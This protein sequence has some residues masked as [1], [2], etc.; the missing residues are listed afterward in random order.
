MALSSDLISQFVQVTKEEKTSKETT[1]YGTIVEYNGGKYVKLDG[2]ELL[3]PISLT[4]DAL[5]GERVTVMIKDHTATVT[6]NLSSPSARTDTVKD[7]DDSVQE[8]GSKVSE[9]EIVIA[10]KVSTKRLEAEIARI[11]T[12]VSENV[13][14]NGRLEANEAEISDLTADNVTINEKLTAND[15]EIENLKAT[16]IDA[17]VVEATYA[18]IE[19]L[20]ATNAHINNLEVTYGK[21]KDLTTDKLTAVDATISNLEVNKLNVT[22]AEIKYANID[23]AN[24]N[25]AAVEK[26]FADS[27][28]I[29]DLIVS[30]GTIT[31][32]LVGVTIK[33]DL[34]E[35]NTIV[36]D[37]LVVKGEDGLYY[38]LNTDGVTTEAEQTDYNSLNGT[39]IQAKSVTAEKIRVDDLVAFGATIGGYHITD[40]AL[41]SGAKESAT[42]TTRG[43][44][45]DNDGQF[46]VGDSTN[47]LRYYK[48]QNGKYELEVSAQTITF[49]SSSKDLETTLEDVEQDIIDA[50]DSVRETMIEQDTNIVSTC[51]ELILS[52]TERYVETGDYDEFKQSIEAQLSVM[53]NEIS[54]N[55]TNTTSSISEVDGE[56]QSFL[57]TFSKYIKFSSDTAIT[58]GSGDNSIVL[59]IDNE[60]GI[61]FKKNGVQFGWWDGVDFHTGNIV[62]EVNERAQ[63]GNFAFVPRSDGSLSFLKIGGE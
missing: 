39:V 2:S 16:K 26:L 54:M 35:G 6:G 51:E 62:V 61:V 48:D 11:D 45:M 22:D 29:K 1:V 7:L 8:I 37:K 4:A 50:T 40:D 59:E 56:L 49:G 3:T 12:L 58:I 28:I 18:D 17:D 15:A 30:E 57:T 23:F 60:T 34:I 32:E 44:Y 27:G 9:F 55:F 33:G 46:S 24:I 38:K 36:A 5:D 52:A 14:I 19:S 42:N 47:F 43:V 41:Y 53:A 10:D 25:M 21:F 20:E 63:F 31:G 13:T